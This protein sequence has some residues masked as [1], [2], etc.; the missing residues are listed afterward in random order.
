MTTRGVDE[1]GVSGGLVAVRKKYIHKRVGVIVGGVRGP[2]T[3]K[4][5]TYNVLSGWLVG[6]PPFG[7]EYTTIMGVCPGG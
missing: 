4:N 7:G 3:K 6:G 1:V 5:D 2:P